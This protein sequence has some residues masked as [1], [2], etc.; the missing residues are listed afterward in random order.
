MLLDDHFD[1]NT[2]LYHEVDVH[3]LKSLCR[4]MNHKLHEAN[5]SA[6]NDPDMAEWARYFREYRDRINNIIRDRQGEPCDFKPAVSPM[7]IERKAKEDREKAK[8]RQ[9][10]KAGRKQRKR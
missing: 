8:R 9:K 4:E 10:A 5:K 7:T 1:K 3:V 6:L 2:T